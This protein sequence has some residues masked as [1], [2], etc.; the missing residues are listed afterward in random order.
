MPPQLI[1]TDERP[2]EVAC[3]AL[4]VP[5]FSANGSVE[6]DDGGR[7]VD[8]ALDGYLTERA[9]ELDF[10][11]HSGTTASVAT[12]RRLPARAV[13]MVGMGPR[14]KVR[15]SDVRTAAGTAARALSKAPVIATTLSSASSKADASRAVAE[16]FLLA[17]YS[18]TKYKSDPKTSKIQQVQIIGGDETAIERGSAVAEAVLLTRDLANEPA[19]A[20]PPEALARR[21]KEIG[22]VNGF[23]VNIW[24]EED[25]ET[26]GFGGLAAVGKGSN[27][28][29]RFIELRYEP[30]DP[31]GT[32]AIVGKGVTF[33]SGGLSLKDAKGMETMKGDMAGAASVI[34]A[35]SVLKR[36][37]VTCAVYAYIPSA[38]NLVSGHSL[39]PGDVVRHYS[40]KTTEVNNTDA[41]GRLILADAL[42][43]ACEQE[44]DAVV[45]VAT[46]TGGI[47][48]ALGLKS[49]GLFC[50]DD[51]LAAQLTDAAEAAGERIWRMPIYDDYKRDIDSEIADVKNS[52]TR[53]G[54]AIIGAVFLKQHIRD[55][56]PWA[57]IDIASADWA[58][59]PYELGPKG[60]TGV[61]TRT[62]I[63]WLERR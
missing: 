9:S 32:V 14:E 6:F 11:G 15:P 8:E 39:K 57:H 48:V 26:R 24:D 30:P 58:D 51:D 12:M 13:V 50:D 63:S 22:D 1:R 2:I 4:V 29:P 18:F 53:W 44:P 49:S 23:S 5:A 38:E 34:G 10:A 62:L 31:T 52:G 35:M 61:I 54:S 19:D 37:G 17:S 60:P 46:L 47:M 16:G 45:D 56:I 42:A 7:A 25:L 36:L 27:R 59:S 21:A 41:E 28:P 40:G 33:D 3:D 43:Y 55:G 20:L